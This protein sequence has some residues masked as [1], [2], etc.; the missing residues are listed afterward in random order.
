ME[1]E[2]P[3]SANGFNFGSSPSHCT[4]ICS[5]RLIPSALKSLIVPKVNPD[6]APILN[7]RKLFRLLLASFMISSISEQNLKKDLEVYHIIERS[8]HWN[9][10]SE[11]G[12]LQRR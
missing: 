6:L 1:P 2:S 9:S 12:T 7:T 3:G 4:R 10:A 5:F 11:L 8:M